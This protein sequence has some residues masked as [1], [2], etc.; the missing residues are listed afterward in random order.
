MRSWMLRSLRARA[1]RTNVDQRSKPPI[2]PWKLF[3]ATPGNGRALHGR[4]RVRL[5]PRSI[6]ANAF[7]LLIET[8]LVE[9][10]DPIAV[11]ACTLCD[12]GQPIDATRLV[13]RLQPHG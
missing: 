2:A 5:R 11:P 9:W 6:A 13:S 7:A 12:D 8:R 4:V 3:A 10:S 1:P